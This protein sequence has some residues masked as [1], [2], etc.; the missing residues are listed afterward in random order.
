MISKFSKKLFEKIS[1]NVTK[2]VTLKHLIVTASIT[3]N[4][5]KFFLKKFT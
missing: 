5:F 1:F 2:V 4:F 3:L